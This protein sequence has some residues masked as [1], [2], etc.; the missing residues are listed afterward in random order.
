MY[1]CINL[2]FNNK[3]INGNFYRQVPQGIPF[4]S[5]KKNDNIKPF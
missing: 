3:C 5:V 1:G 2:Y 4:G